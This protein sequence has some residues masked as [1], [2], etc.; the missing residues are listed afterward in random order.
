M[1][2]AALIVSFAAFAAAMYAGYQTQ[3]QA[4]AARDAA[5]SAAVANE[6]AQQALDEGRAASARALWSDA[7]EAVH[8]ALIDLTSEPIGDRLQTLRIRLIAL[9][10]G[11]PEWDGLDGWLGAEHILGAT[12]GREVLDRVQPGMTVEQQFDLSDEYRA[13]GMALAQNLRHLRNIGHS[14]DDVAE[15]RRIAEEWR[16]RV[17]ERNNW[18]NPPTSPLAPLRTPKVGEHRA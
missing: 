1:E 4:Q 5:E 11:L 3:A 2:W 13:W 16:A 7:I 8:R 18:G 10:D 17:Y 14:P 6:I 12:L 15:L 9:M